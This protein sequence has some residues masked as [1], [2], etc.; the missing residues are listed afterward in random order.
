MIIYLPF[1][2]RLLLNYFSPIEKKY[3]S[4]RE[5]KYPFIPNYFL[6]ITQDT[7]QLFFYA[8]FPDK[9]T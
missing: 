2:Y 7:V 6:M 4:Y 9:I 3:F 8:Q 5:T 1:Y